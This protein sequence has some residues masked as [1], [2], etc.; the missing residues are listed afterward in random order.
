VE[1]LKDVSLRVAPINKNEASDMINE[2]KCGEILKG[3]RGST[4]A[5]ID[6]ITD[7]LEKIANLSLE[8]KDWIDEL[9][10]NPLLVYGNGKGV[11]AIDALVKLRSSK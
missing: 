7:T 4:G 10:I 1:L 8:L 9:D 6:A 11:K 3:F 5:D 2:I